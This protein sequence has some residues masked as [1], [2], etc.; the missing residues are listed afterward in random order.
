MITDR[1]QADVDEA[2]LIR[3]KVQNGETLTTDEQ[4]KYFNG[5]RGAYNISDLNRVESKVGEIR[6]TLLMYGYPAFGIL[7]KINWANTDLLKYSDINRYL[8]NIR[9]LRE[10][11]FTYPQTPATPFTSDWI[12]YITANDIEQILVDIEEILDGMISSFYFTTE[13]YSGD[14]MGVI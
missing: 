11:Y 12:N 7:T 1:T 10:A 9:K 13:I 5:M 3:G 14:Q 6:E 8:L 4:T 2:L